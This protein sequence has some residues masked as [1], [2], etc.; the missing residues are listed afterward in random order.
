MVWLVT[1]LGIAWSGT[2]LLAFYLDFRRD[3]LVASGL[4]PASTPQI[5]RGGWG[6]GLSRGIPALEYVFSRAFAQS[7]DKS[8]R[9]WAPV[10]RA[11]FVASAIMLGLT[12]AL[13]FVGSR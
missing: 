8:T 10:L 12:I 13:S 11:G 9:F 7:A 5:L 4:L 1:G 3:S 6:Y 2:L